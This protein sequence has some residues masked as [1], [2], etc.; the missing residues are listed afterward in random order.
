MAGLEKLRDYSVKFS[1]DM[2]RNK[3]I[4]F[5]IFALCTIF[6]F[7]MVICY[8]IYRIGWIDKSEVVSLSIIVVLAG[9]VG[10]MMNRKRN[11]K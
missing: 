4:L 9:I 1:I 2:I 10:N 11:K 8:C 3:G 6:L 7:T 5:I